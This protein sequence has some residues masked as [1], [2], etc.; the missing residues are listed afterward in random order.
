M[1]E[2]CRAQKYKNTFLFYFSPFSLAVPLNLFNWVQHAW[3]LINYFC[4]NSLLFAEFCV[5]NI[6][7]VCYALTHVPVYIKCCFCFFVT[8][9]KNFAW[10]AL[11]WRCYVVTACK[12]FPDR[13]HRGA[14]IDIVLNHVVIG[15]EQS[16]FTTWKKWQKMSAAI[17]A[18]RKPIFFIK[19]IKE[20]LNL[21][22]VGTLPLYLSSWLR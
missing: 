5:T 8:T 9:C 14:R 20:L 19:R 17:L 13:P 16:T 3:G 2:N 12:N 10:L 7:N 11:S 1:P 18:A 22:Y 4:M 21:I 6:S 15:Q